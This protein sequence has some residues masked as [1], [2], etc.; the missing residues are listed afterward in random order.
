MWCLHQNVLQPENWKNKY[1]K[2]TSVPWTPRG[3]ITLD[4][5]ITDQ[6]HAFTVLGTKGGGHFKVSIREHKTRGNRIF[7]RWRHWHADRDK[8]HDIR[9]LNYFRYWPLDVVGTNCLVEVASTVVGADMAEEYLLPLL[10][11]L[12]HLK[13]NKIFVLVS[14]L[15]CE[16]DIQLS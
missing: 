12:I 6:F 1:V 16:S 15:F 13:I 9:L 5:L 14:L 11:V 10:W 3:I 2:V 8:S 7:S 4:I